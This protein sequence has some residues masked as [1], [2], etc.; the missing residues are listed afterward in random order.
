[1]TKTAVMLPALGLLCL[2]AG[3]LGT[4]AGLWPFFA[5]FAMLGLGLLLGLTGA[6][7]GL[8]VGFKT[9]QWALP[10]VAI[11]V[12]LAV[13]AVPSVAVL[14]SRGAPPINDITTD[15]DNPPPYVD[16]L[17]LRVGALVAAEY[18]GARVAEQQRRAYGDIQPLVLP[19]DRGATF[20][21]VLREVRDLGWE[22]VSS[23]RD[24]GRIE[25]IDT[26]FWFGFKDDVVVRLSAA[27]PGSATRVDVRSK[28]RVGI[29]D[30][31]T[32]ARRVR[33]LL[34][35]VSTPS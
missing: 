11:L 31:G 16:I 23:D 15:P 6:S 24:A 35:R 28:S 27:G 10:A 18:G 21:R 20:D 3:P 34:R 5:G 12:G 25:A 22:V 19:L 26:T 33:E 8:V 13:V 29:G 2:L 9:G 17:P 30:L 7:L 32:N 14:S 1:M 4:R